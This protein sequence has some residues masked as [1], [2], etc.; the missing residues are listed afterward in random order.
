MSSSIKCEKLRGCCITMKCLISFSAWHTSYRLQISCNSLVQSVISNVV[1][2]GTNQ[3]LASINMYYKRYQKPDKERY[4]V[5]KQDCR[6]ITLF[7]IVCYCL[8]A[9][10]YSLLLRYKVIPASICGSCSL[11]SCSTELSFFLTAN[12]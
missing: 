11:E 2:T 5:F 4:R 7:Q 3:S 9:K 6:H 1:E 10:S 12:K 8:V